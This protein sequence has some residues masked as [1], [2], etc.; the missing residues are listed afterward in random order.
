MTPDRDGETGE[1]R[2][3]GASASLVAGA[4]RDRDPLPG[5][6]G[7]AGLLASPPASEDDADDPVLVRDVLGRQPLFVE[8]DAT[9]PTD[10]DAW[11]FDRGCLRD[12]DPVPAGS[13]VS[14]TETGRRW[15]LPTFPASDPEPAR[16]AVDDA[17]ETAL[18]DLA[19]EDAATSSGRLAVAFSGGVDS[20]LIAS[21]VPDV[22]CYVAGFEGCHDVAAA[23]E[24]AAAMDRDLRTVELTHD[25]LR[26]AIPEIAAA[27]G[28]RNPMDLNIAVP[29]YLTAE[30]AAAD[31]I[32]RLTVGQGADEL[33]GGYSKVVD[34][35]NDHR[36]EADTVRGARDETVRTLPRQLE[37]DVLTLRAAGVEPVAPLLDDR[38]VD[39]ALRLPGD[40]LA[41]ADERKVALRRA[42]TGRVPESVRT[43]DKKAV[44]YGTY[45]SREIDRLARQNGFKRRMDDHV[46]Q[47]VD[48]LLEGHAV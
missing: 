15:S 2:L 1:S 28:R 8:A 33:F 41:T 38:V 9:D 21:A 6:R 16:A 10:P 20:A 4:V 23:R 34:P 44:Q 18:S 29:L 11:S 26:R 30:A 24:A 35:A 13:V 27:T 46:G 39:A 22:P 17:I 48:A 7:F 31:G 45:V 25:D 32:E 3:R 36:V 14:A 12:P 47:Y 37:R 43:A 5:T 42:A 19:V 40:L